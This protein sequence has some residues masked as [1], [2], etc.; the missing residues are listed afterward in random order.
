MAALDITER[1]QNFLLDN[2]RESKVSFGTTLDRE[3][4]PLKTPHTRAG[5]EMGLRGVPNLAPCSYNNADKSSFI[6]VL[7]QKPVCRKGYSLGARTGQRFPNSEKKAETPGPPQYQPINSKPKEFSPAEK[8]FQ[9]GAT[10]FPR[11]RQEAMPGPGSYEHGVQ[12]NRSVQFHGS[13][14][15]P[16]TLRTSITTICNNG[17]KDTCMICSKITVGD[18]YRNSKPDAMCRPCYEDLI[19]DGIEKKEKKKFL[20]KFMKVRDCCD[21]HSHEGTNAKMRLKSEKDIKKQ[22]LREAYLSL[23]Y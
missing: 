8:P 11:I 7:N 19:S 1:M 14:G 16:Q 3:L 2:T 12:G 5:N 22:K 9:C 23:Y 18:Y 20:S 21:I 15:G 17:I 10:R 6:H 13:F 4:L